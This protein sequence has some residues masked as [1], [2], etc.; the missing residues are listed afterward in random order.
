MLSLGTLLQVSG[1][2]LPCL[3][4]GYRG[5]AKFQEIARMQGFSTG[6]AHNRHFRHPWKP[7]EL[8]DLAEFPQ[9][10]LVPGR[11]LSHGSALQQAR[12]VFSLLLVVK[13]QMAAGPPARE[14]TLQTHVAPPCSTWHEEAVAHHPVGN[15]F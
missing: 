9:P 2:W 12:V 1:P 10:T 4:S 14:N 15:A 3:Q 6:L 11:G 13:L 8:G 5:I 7:W